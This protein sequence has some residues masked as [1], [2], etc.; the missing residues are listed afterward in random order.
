MQAKW[1][2]NAVELIINYLTGTIK[3]N[4]RA[5]LESERGHRR[6]ENPCSHPRPTCSRSEVVTQCQSSTLGLTLP[7]SRV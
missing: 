5:D 1:M 6:P 3:D 2:L 4:G 7:V